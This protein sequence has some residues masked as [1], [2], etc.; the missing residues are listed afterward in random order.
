MPYTEPHTPHSH[1]RLVSAPAC[2]RVLNTLSLSCLT[3]AHWRW[4]AFFLATDTT[5]THIP[6]PAAGTYPRARKR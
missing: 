4:H 3:L 5:V 6:T 2:V 1:T